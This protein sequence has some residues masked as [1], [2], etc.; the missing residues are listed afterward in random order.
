MRGSGPELSSFPG[1]SRIN[2]HLHEEYAR[3]M[4]SLSAQP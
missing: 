1:L 4:P 2:F 3:V